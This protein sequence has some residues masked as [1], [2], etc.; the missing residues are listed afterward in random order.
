MIRDPFPLPCL[1]AE[2]AL[3]AISFDRGMLWLVAGF[4]LLGWVLARMTISRRRKA[5]QQRG[6]SRETQR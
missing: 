4:L 2:D 1:L 5:I 6:E 3:E